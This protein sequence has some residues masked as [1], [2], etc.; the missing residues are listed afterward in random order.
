MITSSRKTLRK[1]TQEFI[2]DQLANRNNTF[3]Y[4]NSTGRLFL[5]VA[6]AFDK[7]WHQGIIHKML[8]RGYLLQ[9]VK[10]TAP[11]LPKRRFYIKVTGMYWEERTT[12]AGVL[13]GS[14]L[15]PI[16]FNIFV[17]NIPKPGHF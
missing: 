14:L 11:Y 17:S 9:L 15:G 6:K 8:D 2:L 12:T 5:D 1:F 7:V 16:L 13:Q 4:R 3:N 10:L